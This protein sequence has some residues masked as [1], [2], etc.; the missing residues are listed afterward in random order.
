MK[1]SVHIAHMVN[2]V[3]ASS[4]F[5]AMSIAQSSSPRT[6]RSWMLMCRGY[7]Y[8][9]HIILSL[10]KRINLGCAHLNTEK[11]IVSKEV[12]WIFLLVIKN[13]IYRPVRWAC[14][15]WAMEQSPQNGGGPKISY[16]LSM[17]YV[18]Q[19]KQSRSPQNHDY[20]FGNKQV[21]HIWFCNITL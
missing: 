8:V 3:I 11:A 7:R 17:Y 16:V 19:A 10:V 13:T 15:I 4:R 5:T 20:I 2:P 18:Q 12:A 9:Y 6:C 14:S 1:S 21:C